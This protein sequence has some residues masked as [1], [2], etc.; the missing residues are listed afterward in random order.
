MC[1]WMQRVEALSRRCQSCLGTMHDH[2][3]YGRA[4]CPFHHRLAYKVR[5]SWWAVPWLCRLE[6]S[7]DR[8][9]E[10]CLRDGLHFDSVG[11]LVVS[12]PGAPVRTPRSCTNAQIL[13][14]AIG[15]ELCQRLQSA[16]SAVRAKMEAKYVHVCVRCV[17]SVAETH[18]A[19]SPWRCT[20]SE[21]QGN[22]SILRDCRRA[23]HT[24]GPRCRVERVANGC[25]E[26]AGPHPVRELDGQQAIQ[27]VCQWQ[28][29]RLLCGVPSLDQR[30]S[31][32]LRPSFHCE[33]QTGGETGFHRWAASTAL[34]RCWP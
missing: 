12:E 23:V 2:G 18:A 4:I 34:P 28:R 5:S 29:L 9:F 32:T 1:R 16:V 30:C 27:L 15:K 17:C 19:L 8:R 11:D 25:G 14:P 13:P 26:Q 24:R 33:K 20:Q 6:P 10:N 3:R 22:A 21:G 7:V 31:I